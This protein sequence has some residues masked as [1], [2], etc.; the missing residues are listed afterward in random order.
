MPVPISLFPAT[1][2]SVPCTDPDISNEKGSP[3]YL[4]V[5]EDLCLFCAEIEGRPTLQLKVS[6]CAA[7]ERS[8]VTFNLI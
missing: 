2:F 7:N 8:T 3:I 4:G 5:K 1:V 6:G